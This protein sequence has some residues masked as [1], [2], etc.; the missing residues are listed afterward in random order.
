MPSG[1]GRRPAA[2]PPLTS[3]ALE[4]SYSRPWT[5]PRTSPRFGAVIADIETGFND[6]RPRALVAHFTE[7]ATA[8]DVAGRLLAG[9]EAL[10]AAPARGSRDRSRTSTRATSWARSRS[11][12]RTWRS[13]TSAPGAVAPDGTPLDLGH[14][15]IA[16]YVFVRDGG[17]GAWQ[18]DRTRWCGPR[19]RRAC[20]P[21]PLRLLDL[22]ARDRRRGRLRRHVRR[23]DHVPG[24]DEAR[25]A[26]SPLRAQ[27]PARDQ[28]AHGDAGARRRDR[29]RHVPGRG[30]AAETT[31]TCGSARRSPSR[32]CWAGCS[33]ATSSPPT[34]GSARSPR[35]SGGG[36]RRPRGAVGGVPAR[37]APRGDR[38]PVTGLLLVI[39]IFLMVTKPGA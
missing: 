7:D 19:L 17:A 38:R 14:T 8:V 29:D 30:G 39:A 28:P 12:P 1:T 9:R 34:S 3:S 21:S 22:P 26:P 2:F 33:A 32:S 4:P 27:A 18:R 36:R 37:R 25:P 11:S 6:Q 24:R 10:L 23:G 20:S 16:L 5:A 35:A 13:P 15:M 31:A